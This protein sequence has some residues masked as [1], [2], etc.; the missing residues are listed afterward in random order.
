MI[1]SRVPAA[2]LD[3]SLAACSKTDDKSQGAVAS[4]GLAGPVAVAGVLARGSEDSATSVSER[5]VEL[6]ADDQTV[7]ASAKT[8]ATGA[9]TLAIEAPAALR[10]AGA[11]RAQGAVVAT[12]RT[13]F[14]TGDASPSALGLKQQLVVDA[15]DA[16]AT[17][18]GGK[19]VVATGTRVAKHVGAIVGSLKLQ[20]GKDPGAVFLYPLEPVGD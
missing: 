15:R 11:G 8:D 10:L 20:S 2:V 5:A 17:T 4:A 1:I 16:T 19:A 13:H 18:K 6:V 9:F 14:L 12:L 7:L 3:L